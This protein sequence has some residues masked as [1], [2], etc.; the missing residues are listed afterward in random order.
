MLPMVYEGLTSTVTIFPVRVLMKI[1]MNPLDFRISVR[2][3]LQLMW[4]SKR[5]PLSPRT[6]LLKISTC[7]STDI[8]SFI[9]IFS[10][11]K[12]M[13]SVGLVSRKQIILPSKFLMDIFMK[14]PDL[15]QV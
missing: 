3:D 7:S 8:P 10:F 12:A 4:K 1:F 5:V 14:A 15:R 9:L 13:V 2:V 11:T 6:I